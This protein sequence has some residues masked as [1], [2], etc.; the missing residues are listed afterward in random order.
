[1]RYRLEI[2]T[3]ATKWMTL[4]ENVKKTSFCLEPEPE[5]A[6]PDF[7]RCPRNSG[8]YT[9]LHEQRPPVDSRSRVASTHSISWL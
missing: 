4:Y 9:N 5:E 2:W 8:N 3:T 1:M 7:D 6:D